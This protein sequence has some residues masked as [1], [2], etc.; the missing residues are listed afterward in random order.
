ML[1]SVATAVPP[2][3][4]QPVAACLVA[5][6]I[7]SNIMHIYIYIIYI[8]VLGVVETIVIGVKPY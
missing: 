5:M 4:R 1:N 3:A 6:P 2:P 7:A 8:Y